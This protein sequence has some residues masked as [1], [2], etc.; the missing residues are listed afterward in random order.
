M[1]GRI[2]ITDE[3]YHVYNRGVDKREVYM[4]PDDYSYFIHLLYI[5]NDNKKANNTNRNL[6]GRGSTSTKEGDRRTCLV[7][8]LS[9][10]LMPNH[11][12]LLLKQRQEGGIAKFMQKV[13]TGYT[14]YFNEKY[15]RSG[16]LFQGR[17]KS[18]YI[19]DD[20][21]LLYIP[22]YIHLNPVPLM[23]KGKNYT[24][25]M[26]LEQYKWSSYQDYIGKKNFPSLIKPSFILDQF[27]GSEAYVVDINKFLSM[28][29]TSTITNDESL[30][31]D[32][33][34]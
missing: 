14:M 4:T 5:L 17:Y 6:H 33:Q 11:Y 23:P 26:Y 15:S 13:G 32:S 12:H 2:H 25:A 3:T 16:S 1:N 29:A 24:S 30:L 22:H 19:H 20:R 27:G 7:D 10:C 31:I 28:D 34:D 8:I 21:Q 18:V 9:F